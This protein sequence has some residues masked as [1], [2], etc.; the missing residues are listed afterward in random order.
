MTLFAASEK[1][2][3]FFPKKI[4]TDVLITEHIWVD[5]QEDKEKVPE[6]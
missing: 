1:V 6:G 2:N 3:T 4:G 5:L